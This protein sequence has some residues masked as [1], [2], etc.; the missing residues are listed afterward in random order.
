MNYL[1]LLKE[2]FK[3]LQYIDDGLEPYE[4]L[5]NYI[6]DF[7][8]YDRDGANMMGEEALSVCLA[9]TDKRIFDYI[10]DKD[11]YKKYLNY[12]NSN[13]FI[14]KLDWGT[15]IRCAWWDLYEDKEFEIN[16]WDGEQI[17]TLKFKENEW[18]LFVYAMRDFVQSQLV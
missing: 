11:N 16:S 9:I 10:E 17:F 2:N 15:S 13:F 14:D 7:I 3:T 6:F 4:Y 1:D 12:V 8:T 5:S 18:D